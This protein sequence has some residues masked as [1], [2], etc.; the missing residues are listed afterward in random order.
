M[1]SVEFVL[2]IKPRGW[3]R[4]IPRKFGD[5]VRVVQPTVD[6]RW[7][8]ALQRFAAPAFG[9]TRFEKGTA[10]EVSILAVFPRPKR[11]LR[12]KDPDGL[13]P[14]TQK[15]DADNVAKLVLDGLAPFWGDD[16]Q[17]SDLIVRK[18]YVERD[19]SPRVE[20]H[21]RIMCG[22]GEE[23]VDIARPEETSGRERR[24]DTRAGST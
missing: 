10:L 6:K 12:K 16:A 18:R 24:A 14:Q 3:G 19:E 22:N 5:F 4:A 23:V 20:V 7:Q 11:L 17:V 1:N 2:P 15:P 13:F 8:E 9:A 21:I